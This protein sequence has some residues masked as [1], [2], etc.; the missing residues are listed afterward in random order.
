HRG[1]DVENKLAAAGGLEVEH[2]HQLLPAKQEIVREYVPV[3]YPLGQ[4]AF[5]V[6]GQVLDF[7]VE[8]SADL[9]KIIG[10][11]AS[12]VQVEIGNSFE[13]E[14]VVDSLLVRFSDHMQ[15]ADGVADG[16]QL[17]E[18]ELL[19]CGDPALLILE[20][21]HALVVESAMVAT[22]PILHRMGTG[23]SVLA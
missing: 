14:P 15:L 1:R 3:D 11:A 20:Q 17:R 2:R 18:L 8:G 7:V 16:F 13:A 9:A 19:G 22:H 12:H 6:S 4:L 5:E 10:Q 23:K 21:R